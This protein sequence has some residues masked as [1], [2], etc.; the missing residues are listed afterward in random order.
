MTDTDTTTSGT[1]EQVAATEPEDERRK[2]DLLLASAAGLLTAVLLFAAWA[3]WSWASAPRELGSA[4]ARDQA[5]EAGQQAVLNFNTLDYRHV[6]RGV[7]LWEQSSTGKLHAQIVAGQA[8]FEQQIARAR[9]ITIARILDAALTKLNLA[10]GRATIIV[11]IQITVTPAHGKLS[12]KQSRLEGELA[13]TPS[14][15]K[16]ADLTQ[17]PVGS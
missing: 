6:A 14:G 3:G 11:A 9:T 4:A 15:W 17:V 8:G 5:L 1:T 12:V 16:L 13:R 10:A 7:R 2:L